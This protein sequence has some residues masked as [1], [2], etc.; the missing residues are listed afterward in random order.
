MNKKLLKILS[1]I[2]MC[3]ILLVMM[4]ACGKKESEEKETEAGPTKL[5]EEFATYINNKEIEKVVKLIDMKEYLKI[6]NNIDQ[7]NLE[8][9]LKGMNIEAYEVSNI[10]KASEEEIKSVAQEYG[11]EEGST[12]LYKDYEKYAV[13]YKI[14]VDGTE[15]KSN[16]IFFIKEENGEY[17]LVISKVWQGLIVYNYMINNREI[18][19]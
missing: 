6:S 1:I 7:E 15:A 4:T 17:S 18:E 11:A 2:L 5:I 12:D 16:D 10:R 13:D 8:T 9:I 14:K 19:I 3:A